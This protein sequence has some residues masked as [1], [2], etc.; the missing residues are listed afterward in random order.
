MKKIILSLAGVLAATAF[1]PEASAIP[2]FARQTGMACSACH[3]QSFPILT[4][5]G[6]SFKMSGFTMMGAQGKVEGEQGLSIPDTL[7]M[8]V[9]AKLRYQRTNGIEGTGTPAVGEAA[10]QISTNS[11]RFDFPDEFAL[12]AAGR[13]TDNV[14]ALVEISI[15]G[16][17]G[18]AGIANFKFPFVSDVGSMK[19]GVVPFSGDAGVA[20]GFDLFA[21]GS[22]TTGRVI[23]NAEGYSTAKYLGTF[24]PVTGIAVY[25]AND[26]FH[27]NFTPWAQGDQTTAAGLNASKVG[28][29][30]IRAGWT[31]SM[32]G[33][34]IGVGVQNWSGNSLD[35]VGI[36]ATGTSIDPAAHRDSAFIVDAQAQGAVADMPLGIYGSFGRANGQTAGAVNTFNSGTETRSAFG[37]LAD[38]G[39]VPETLGVQFGILRGKTGTLLTGSNETDNAI[40]LGARYKFRQNVNMGVAY[41]KFSGTAYGAGGSMDASVAGN[42]GDSLLNLTLIASF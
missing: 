22:N 21:T 24:T 31:P 23:E 39:V 41:T 40:T 9:V 26:D 28:G 10:A 29:R 20:Y 18:S 7:N 11:G 17:P 27:V 32:A 13:V 15:A 3:F 25:A 2:A 19:L 4:K 42:T 36:D 6:K 16:E 33:W 8:A 30:Y 5:F 37:L 38:L 34:D 35:G 1:A 12:F 14:G